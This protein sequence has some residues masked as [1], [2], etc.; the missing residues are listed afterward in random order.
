MKNIIIVPDIHGR[1]F[2]KKLE[3]VNVEDYDVIFL[4]DM[5][6]VYQFDRIKEDDAVNNFKDIIEF[7]K[8]YPN[9][10]TLLLGNHDLEYF[11]DITSCRMDL[12]NKDEIKKLFTDNLSLFD[13]GCYRE[14]NGKK[15]TFTHSCILKGWVDFVNKHFGDDLN[16]KKCDTI[17]KLIDKLNG[18]L[19]NNNMDGISKCMN[20]VSYMRSGRF[21]YGSPVWAHWN[22]IDNY[23]Y[24]YD[25]YYQ[26]FGHSQ[27]FSREM[28][29][30]INTV[31]YTDKLAEPVI[32]KWFACLDCKQMFTIIDNKVE[33]FK[34]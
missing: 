30:E 17:E 8:Q 18:M 24:E 31:G 1:T 20:M 15:Y 14:I 22:E 21:A 3:S 10:V 33:K 12:K 19:H 11:A 16:F 28:I 34:C 5:C 2:W 9:N 6:D 26:V 32:T 7:K 25:E 13:I 29:D 23:G 27:Q 4:G